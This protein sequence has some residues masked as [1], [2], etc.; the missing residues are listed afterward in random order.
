MN[1]AEFTKWQKLVHYVVR[2]HF[3]WAFRSTKEGDYRRYRRHLDYNDLVQ[4]G[5]VALLDAWSRWH[6]GGGASFKTYA[7]TAILR[8]VHR[9]IDANACPVTTKNWQSAARYDD[10]VHEMLAAAV[11]CRLF[12]ESNIKGQRIDDA[13]EIKDDRSAQSPDDILH[14]DWVDH[15]MKRLGRVLKKKEIK[16]LLERSAGKTFTQIGEK[17]G[18]TRERARVVYGE[19]L[20]RAAVVLMDQEVNLDG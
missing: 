15:C 5:N 8:K 11:A 19:L 13:P 1:D 18:I 9:F 2:T 16:I 3:S 4:E 20:V 12:S 10:S 17:R 6:E 7:Y 14:A